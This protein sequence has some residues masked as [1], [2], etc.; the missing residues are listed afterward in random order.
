MSQRGS[1]RD[2]KKGFKKKIKR[3]VLRDE[4]KGGVKGVIP[5][6]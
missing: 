3:M 6:K 2:E 1:D 4:T 5:E